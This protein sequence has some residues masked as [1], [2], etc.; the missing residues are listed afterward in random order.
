M[1]SVIDIAN[2]EAA[3]QADAAPGTT[4]APPPAPAVHLP[5]RAAESEAPR[6]RRGRRPRL[7]PLTRRIVAVNVLPL[8]LLA[9]GFLYLGK[10][11]ASLIGQ[12][13]EALRTQGEIFAAALGEGAV[14][15]S[16]DEG[17]TLLPDL[18]RQMMR[19][20]VAPTHTPARLFDRDGKLIAD[21]RVLSGPGDAVEVSELPPPDNKGELTRFGLR[22]YDWLTGLLPHPRGYPDYRGGSSAADFPEADRALHGETG[23]AVRRDPSDS[24]LVISVAVPVQR[25]KEVLGAVMLSSANGDIEAE[26]RTVRFEVLRIFGVA[27]LVTLLL[28]MY[29]AGT[30]GRPIR[31]LAEAAE[32]V[33]GR[34]ARVDIP[35]LTRRG[36]EIGDLS[37]SLREMTDALWL[38]MSAIESFASD[39]AHEIKN[40]LSSL[41]SA[42]ETAVRIDDPLKQQRLLAIILDDV[43]RL[44]RLITDISD[45]SRLD[46]EM[47][48]DVLEPINL[49]AMLRALVDIHETTRSEGAA[50]VVLSLPDRRRDL[51]V[52]G[53]ES[54]LSQVFLNLISNAVSFSPPG[55]EIRIT[56]REDGR[57]VIVSIDDD[58]P[59]IPGEKLTTIFDRFYTE[60]PAAE[61]F[62]THSGL[63][64][65]IS[66]QIVEAHRGRIWAENRRD[67][68]GTVCG[69]RFLLRLPQA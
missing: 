46:A 40:P 26:L 9:L 31:R 62:G 5:A 24:G 53:L 12:Q 47:S 61:K 59:G 67:A 2:T 56:A 58:G 32:R 21:S 48:R 60:R 37:R 51:F 68:T 44:S 63:G 4:A 42:V 7:S 19:R 64:L 13:V 36:D 45:A 28:S 29:L 14:L 15:D 52:Q 17:E 43:E 54:R 16:P 55:G 66:K 69:A 18:A 49:A 39:V 3:P 35:D 65:S 23:S 27:L 8:A 38:R 33:R 30:I 25:Y 34:G 41:R 50:R 57:A 22:A 1:A 11:E 10:F 20:L 6:R